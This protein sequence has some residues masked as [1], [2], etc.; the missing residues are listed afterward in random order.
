MVSLNKERSFLAG[1]LVACI[2]LPA[3]AG[4]WKFT[5]PPSATKVVKEDRN[6]R[7]HS[8]LELAVRCTSPVKPGTLYCSFFFQT[9][10]DLWF[11]SRK[12]IFLTGEP[13]MLRLRLDSLSPDWHCSNA[14]RAFA[15]DVLRWVRAW[16]IKVFSREQIS[17][18]IE[19][20]ELG[21][22]KEK[23]EPL[24]IF[25][26]FTP[27]QPVAGVVS[28]VRFR[29]GGFRGNFFKSS[30]M[31]GYLLCRGKGGETRA[32]V[33]FRQ[34][35]V[36]TTHPGTRKTMVEPVE[37]PVW[38]ADWRPASVGTYEL[39][40]HLATIDGDLT[41]KLGSFEVAPREPGPPGNGRTAASPAQSY[42]ATAGDT[43]AYAYRGGAWRYPNGKPAAGEYWRVHLDWTS[44]WGH[45]TGLGEFDQLLA[46]KLEKYLE[47][48]PEEKPRPILV[49]TQDVLDDHGKF[50][51]VDHPLNAANG[52]RLRQASDIFLSDTAAEIVMDRARY[53]WARYG[54]FE[55]VSGLLLLVDRAEPEVVRWVGKIAATLADEFPDAQVL[56]NSRGLPERWVSAELRLF[57]KWEKDCRLSIN[58]HLKVDEE[59]KELDLVAS[60][61]DTAAVVITNRTWHWAAASAFACDVKSRVGPDGE[62]KVMLFFRT[63]PATV[64]QSKLV[65]LR[66]DTW[67]RVTFYFDDP[68]W[69]TCCRDKE[70]QLTQL[71][72]M[73]IR[74]MG[75]RFFCR[76]RIKIP[77][78]VKNCTLLGPYT[79]DHEK[80]LPFEI[81]A[82]RGDEERVVQH[83]KFELVFRLNRVFNNPYDPEEI[84]VSIELTDPNGRKLR[85]PGYY[86]ETWDLKM[87]DGKETPVMSGSPT[88]RVR[89]TP[90][91]PGKYRWKLTAVTGDEKAEKSGLFECTPGNPRGFLRLSRR[92]PRYMEFSNGEFYYPIGHNLR[93]PS[94]RRPGIYGSE[95][96]AN[97]EWA[98]KQ[99]TRAYGKWFRKMRENGETFSR[100]WMSPWWCGLEWH[101]DHEGFHG[102]G[103]YNQ[104]NAARLDRILE[105]AEQEGI[106]LNVETANHGTLSTYIDKQW[107]YN[108][109]NM[110]MPDGY[111]RYATDFFTSRRAMQSHRDKLR[112]TVAR[113]GYSTA[114]AWWGVMT[115]AEWVEPYFRGLQ[116]ADPRKVAVRSWVPRPYK[117]RAHQSKL[118]NWLV[119][120]DRY[121][122]ELDAHPHL[123]SS[124]FSNPP[125]GKELW[126]RP[127]GDIVHN[128]AYTS[129]VGY[130]RKERFQR[131]N[132]C[133]DV[134]YVF[135]DVYQPYCRAKPLLIG[136]W[137]GDPHKNTEDHLTAELHTGIWAIAMTPAGGVTGYWWWNLLDARDLYPHFKAIASFMKGEDRRGKDFK[138]ER[139]FLR[140][141]G[142]GVRSDMGQR[143]GLVLCSR[144]E[145]F[146]YVY[147]RG[148]NR[149]KDSTPARGFDDPSFPE[150]GEG[151]LIVP[152]RLRDG[153]YTL[154]Y[155]NTFTGQPIR[156]ETVVISG[157]DRSIPLINHRVD[158]ALKLKMKDGSDPRRATSGHA[159]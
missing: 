136:E 4:T 97:V 90:W 103:Y 87:V 146:A 83:E 39:E 54:R 151:K 150:S 44:K 137:A 116:F 5:V 17:G 69:W 9:K 81:R 107:R 1:A 27:K 76:P 108:P 46:W 45:Y 94:D 130:W 159:R 37:T 84:D 143:D 99:G 85:H 139:A 36:R 23:G 105:L 43:G 92:D 124:H 25:E 149:R 109:L 26:V 65:P 144:D 31:S 98:E 60:Y 48:R 102:L 35:Y 52:G 68:D 122:R 63:D 89:V 28:P 13:Q 104:A 64:W 56:C 62:S 57:D 142:R 73:T 8:A 88:W 67:D 75:L 74:E 148:I 77:V 41:K 24:E 141:P 61:T 21:L 140:F 34:D 152:E 80:T 58:T 30:H 18:T 126:H 100:I 72:L 95:V 114:I 32:P 91:V 117:T 145:L 96:L 11:E 15:P 106:Y 82:L 115:E 86:H 154:E 120:T 10:N 133:A 29:L 49:F 131:S 16:G 147:S 53:L 55:S 127:G 138:S 155:W 118:I 156:T 14:R 6:W 79:I 47:C 66:K 111:L 119:E 22:L 123:V 12:G 134:I 19:Y 2:V 59:M 113:W 129:F 71:D 157:R 153:T 135:C 112:Y 7:A 121:I 93:S 40:L 50:N 3:Q 110:A 38:Q 158:L 33:Y 101:R 70:R 20:G 125:N 128:N 78:R 132:G 42:L 51:W